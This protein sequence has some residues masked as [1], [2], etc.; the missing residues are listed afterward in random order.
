LES[1]R[2]KQYMGCREAGGERRWKVKLQG[3]RNLLSSGDREKERK[4]KHDCS[5]SSHNAAPVREKPSC[6]HLHMHIF[7]IC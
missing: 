1:V 2:E 5:L 3:E 4:R 6:S 7:Y